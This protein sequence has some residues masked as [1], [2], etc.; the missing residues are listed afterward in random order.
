MAILGKH[1]RFVG[2]SWV[3]MFMF[4]QV[5]CFGRRHDFFDSILIG[6]YCV[7]SLTSLAPRMSTCAFQ[8]TSSLSFTLT[9]EDYDVVVKG[10]WQP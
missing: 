3:S 6:P 5:D 4:R 9:C 7:V 8:D 2:Y 10:A 1:R